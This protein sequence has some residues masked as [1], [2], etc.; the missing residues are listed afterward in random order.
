MQCST[1]FL[2][3]WSFGRRKRVFKI[4][5]IKGSPLGPQMAPQSVAKKKTPPL[6]YLPYSA[7]FFMPSAYLQHEIVHWT[8]RN[9]YLL[10][11]GNVDPTF[12]AV[13]GLWLLGPVETKAWTDDWL[14]TFTKEFIQVSTGFTRVQRHIVPQ[15]S[16]LFGLSSDR[17]LQRELMH[18]SAVKIFNIIKAISG[19]GGISSVA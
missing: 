15:P 2:A 6:G 16:M 9:L 7:N 13:L 14:T 1:I 19:D 4:K 3:I 8:R 11:I 12:P 17:H 10:I 5:V 18:L